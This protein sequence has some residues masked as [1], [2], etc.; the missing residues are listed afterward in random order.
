MNVSS[1]SSASFPRSVTP[2]KSS[3]DRQSNA[4]EQVAITD[5]KAQER[6]QE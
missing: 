2:S 6:A 5:N 4:H 3:S 1:V